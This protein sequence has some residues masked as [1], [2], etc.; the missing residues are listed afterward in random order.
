M[1]GNFETDDGPRPEFARTYNARECATI[2][3][4]I[5]QMNAGMAQVTLWIGKTDT[6]EYKTIYASTKKKDR[7]LLVV[8]P[9]TNATPKRIADILSIMEVETLNVTGDREHLVPGCGARAEKFLIQ[10]LRRI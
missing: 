6:P 1:L 4:R 5:L 3:S 8:E 10:M 7:G 2:S 9:G